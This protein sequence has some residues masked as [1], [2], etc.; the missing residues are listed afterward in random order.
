MRR[1]EYNGHPD[2]THW[3][4]SM[5]LSGDEGSYC[6]VMNCIEEMGADVAASNVAEAL[7]GLRTPDGAFYTKS[8][9]RRAVIAMGEEK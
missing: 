2:W 5:W 3:N 9:V 8:A 1:V 6:W 4:V 7:D